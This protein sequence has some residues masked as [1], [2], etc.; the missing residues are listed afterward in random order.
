MHEGY[1]D[2]CITSKIV[3]EICRY[4]PFTEVVWIPNG[5]HHQGV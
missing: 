5:I 2:E 3:L 4:T 1:S